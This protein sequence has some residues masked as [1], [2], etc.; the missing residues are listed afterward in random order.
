MWQFDVRTCE[1]LKGSLKRTVYAVQFA[2]ANL[3]ISD[4][5]INAAPMVIFGP[6]SPPA[7]FNALALVQGRFSG[8]RPAQAKYGP[9]F[10]L[11]VHRHI[12]NDRQ[13]LKFPPV[14][15]A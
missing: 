8:L 1:Q 3:I 2:R 6:H 4:V 5:R 14:P 15:W 10:G 9:C 7:A 13:A 11:K 12:R